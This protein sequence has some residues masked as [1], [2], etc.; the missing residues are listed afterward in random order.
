MK[1]KKNTKTKSVELNQQLLSIVGSVIIGLGIIVAI[2]VLGWHY[3]AANQTSKDKKAL[4]AATSTIRSRNP[5]GASIV[6]ERHVFVGDVTAVNAT[7]MTV[8]TTSGQTQTAQ[9]NSKTIV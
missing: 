9:L 4:A 1:D 8:K 7:S 3:G 6:A 2:F 5:L